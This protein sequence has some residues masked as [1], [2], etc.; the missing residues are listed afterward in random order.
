MFQEIKNNLAASV[1]TLGIYVDYRKAYDMVWHAG[2][3]VKLSRMQLPPELLKIIVNWLKNRE[4]RVTYGNNKSEPFQI[5]V[6]LPQGSALSPYIFIIY[7]ADIVSCV[8]AF[9]THIF[10]DDLSVLITP[11]VNKD[12]KKMLDFINKKGTQI[13]QNLL[14]YSRR[15]RQPINTSKTVVQ[16]FHNQVERPEV[17]IYM[18]EKL[19]ENVRAFKYLG[20]HWTDKLSLAPTV[21][22]CLEKIQKSYIKLKWLKR[23]RHITTEVLRTCFFP[24]V[25][26]SSHGYFLFSLC[27]QCLIKNH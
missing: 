15:W 1:P 20:F 13:C 9:S 23:N 7:H 26:P 21:N 10:A 6:G 27:F 18:G 3:I 4:A 17:N 5:E 12:I 19:L 11:P 24:T 2:L 22:S 25:S 14:E 16:L 8:E